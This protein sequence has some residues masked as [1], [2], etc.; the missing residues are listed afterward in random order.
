[1][2]AGRSGIR[3]IRQTGMRMRQNRIP[4]RRIAHTGTNRALA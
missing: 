1:M 3:L 4:V 2:T